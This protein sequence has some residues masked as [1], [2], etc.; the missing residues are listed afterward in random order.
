MKKGGR[1]WLGRDAGRAGGIEDQRNTIDM[2]DQGD[3]VGPE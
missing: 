3:I 2:E 1:T